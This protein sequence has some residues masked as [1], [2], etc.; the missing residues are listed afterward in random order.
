MTGAAQIHAHSA[1][2]VTGAPRLVRE[3]SVPMAECPNCRVLMALGAEGTTWTVRSP[4]DVADRLIMQLGSLEREE[5]V[6]V[7]MNS[8]NGVVAQTTVYRGNVS[9]SVVRVGELFTEAIRQ[10]VPRLLLAHN[11]PSGD[12]TPS[13]DDL[14]LTAT[15]IA[16]GRLLDVEVLDHIIVAGGTYLSV[17]DRGLPGSAEEWGR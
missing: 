1:R 15:A 8:K 16:A 2:N 10:G 13:P 9:S 14:H 6:V 17:R 12:L 5:L 7:L 11:H 3:T 4:R